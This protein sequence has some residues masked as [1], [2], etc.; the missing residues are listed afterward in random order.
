MP[1]RSRSAA[2][3]VAVGLAALASTAASAEPQADRLVGQMAQ[4]TDPCRFFRGQALAQGI[5]DYAREMLWACEEISRRR[6][7]QIPLGDRLEA[8][9]YRLDAY[10]AAI[11]AAGSAA[12]ARGGQPGLP[13]RLFGL[14]DDEKLAI[15]DA[16]GTLLALEAIRHGF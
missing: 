6:A 1:V 11:L 15:A 14:S 3:A 10:R 12:F 9:G 4:E 13:P 8:T 5:A 2:V 16:T 7:A